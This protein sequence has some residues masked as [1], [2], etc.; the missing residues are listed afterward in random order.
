VD[1][2]SIRATGSESR[3]VVGRLCTLAMTREPEAAPTAGS[4]D[5]AYAADVNLGG[6]GGSANRFAVW[7]KISNAQGAGTMMS[8]GCAPSP[9]TVAISQAGDVRGEGDFNCVLGGT[10]QITGLL[11]ISG[12]H[13]G[14][15]LALTF[16]SQRGGGI[17][18][19]RLARQAN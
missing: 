6:S 2:N 11:A 10:Q 16:Q 5:G 4:Y 8:P 18:D 1:G 13:D 14:K 15:S 3:D 7:L 17:R 9:F 12:R 19:L